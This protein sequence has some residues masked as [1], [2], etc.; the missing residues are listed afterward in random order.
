MPL[1]RRGFV[2]SLG[3]GSAGA[4]ALPLVTGRLAAASHPRLLGGRSPSPL[5]RL[6]RNENP[7]GPGPE[8]IAAI[9]AIFMTPPIGANSP[10]SPSAGG[11]RNF[12]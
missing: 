5:L 1:S 11:R 4:V 2:R 9:Q 12:R 10:V 3:L 7:N 8:A 6:D